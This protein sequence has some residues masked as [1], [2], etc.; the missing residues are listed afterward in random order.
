MCEAWE[1]SIALSGVRSLYM[2]GL[3]V[4]HTGGIL[5]HSPLCVPPRDNI[6]IFREIYV[7]QMLNKTS[8]NNWSMHAQSCRQTAWLTNSGGN[9][10]SHMLLTERV[11]AS[12]SESGPHHQTQVRHWE[13]NKKRHV[14]RL[15]QSL[16]F[17]IT[18]G[19]Q[20]AEHNH[21]HTW[22]YLLLTPILISPPLSFV[23]PSIFLCSLPPLPPTHLLW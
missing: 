15:C 17:S 21:V 5:W 16:S 9:F 11:A 19:L 12:H 2:E 20:S 8:L 10:I 3:G 13:R 4:G 6:G 14:N 7:Q 1:H 18:T 22:H 23:S